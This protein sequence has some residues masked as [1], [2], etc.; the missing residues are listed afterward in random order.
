MATPRTTLPWYQFS[1]WSLLLLVFFVAVLCSLGVCTHWLVSAVVALTVTI[2]GIAGRIVAGTRLGFPQGAVFGIQAVLVAVLVCV[3]FGFEGVW[4][5]FAGAWQPSW[6][7]W[8]AIGIAA[9]IGGILGG[10][11]V[12]SRSGL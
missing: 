2:G 1:L 8:V 10:F 5:N 11:T 7:F 9:L 4:L 6:R 12:R 3:L